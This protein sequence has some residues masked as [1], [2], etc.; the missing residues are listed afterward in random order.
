MQIKGKNFLSSTDFDF[1]DKVVLLRID[2]DVDLK[3]EKGQ[4]VVDEDFRLK[5]VL[6]TIKFLQGRGVSKIIMLGHLGR[7]EGKPVKELSLKPVAVWFSE[8]FA[9]CE[10][11]KDISVLPGQT[12][13]KSLLRGGRLV[14]RKPCLPTGRF[15]EGGMNSSDGGMNNLFLLENLRFDP[16]EEAND[17]NFVAGL[18]SLAEVYVNDAFGASHRDHASITG[19]AKILPS[20]LG[21]RFEVEVKTLSWIKTKA[22]RPLVFVLGGSKQGK[23]DY[24]PF[25]VN[26]ADYLLVGGKLP[27]LIQNSKIPERFPSEIN[28][29]GKNQ[30]YNSKI[31]IG[32]LKKGGR[33]ISQESIVNFKKIINSAA[34]VFWAGPM[35]VYEEEENRQGTFEIAKAISRLSGSFSPGVGL[36]SAGEKRRTDSSDGGMNNVFKIAGGGDTHRILSWLNLWHKFDFVSVGGGAALQFLKDDTLPGIEAIKNTFRHPDPAVTS[37]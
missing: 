27:L 16:G 24:I 30:K 10:L 12:P 7:P 6:P 31:Q 13:V 5:S 29:V 35:G 8:N 25:L 9:F 19:L 33:D 17:K 4:L 26:W 14:R 18:A 34:T 21:L 15:G 28:G 2:C 36:D 32:R 37:G 23:L 11:I 3:E 22:E 20:F 1:K